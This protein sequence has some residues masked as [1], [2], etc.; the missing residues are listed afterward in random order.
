MPSFDLF[1]HFQLDLTLEK[2]WWINGKHYGQTSED[3]LKR[4]DSNT[5]MWIGSNREGEL[6]TKKDTKKEERFEEGKMTFYRCVL[7]IL[8]HKRCESFETDVSLMYVLS[9]FRIFYLAC[10]VFFAMHDGEVYGVGHYLFKQRDWVVSLELF[11][12]FCHFFIFETS[13]A[14]PRCAEPCTF[15]FLVYNNIVV[16]CILDSLCTLILKFRLLSDLV[17]SLLKVKLTIW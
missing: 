9:R 12:D 15:I 14:V 16:T 4:Q 13:L 2:S 5:K 6:V 1:N 8:F 11:H 10:A 3:W 7:S 17:R